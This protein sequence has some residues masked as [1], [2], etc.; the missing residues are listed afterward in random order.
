MA[1]ETNA[2]PQYK[3]PTPKNLSAGRLKRTIFIALF[4]AVIL[5]TIIFGLLF[6][7]QF[8]ETL[9]RKIIQ[10]SLDGLN[11]TV[12]N[13]QLKLA[14]FEKISVQL[15]I[16]KGF[17]TTVINYITS[18][19]TAQL[20]FK[21][22]QIESYFN[23]YMISNQDIFA[24][25]FICDRYPERSFV[26]AKDDH[27]AFLSLTQHFMETHTYQNI[28]KAGGG[29]VW[30][31]SI[32]LGI[33]HYVVLGREIKNMADGEPLGV[34]AIFVDEEKIDQLSNL[35]VYKQLNISFSDLENYNLIINNNGEIVSSPFKDDIG[36]NVSGLMKNTQP[37][38]DIFDNKVS[39]RDYGNEINQGSFITEIN[40]KQTLVTYKTIGSQS[41]IG[42]KS[43]WHMLNLTPTSPLYDKVNKVSVLMFLVAVL[44]GII[45]I[46]AAN[47]I[48]VSIQKSY[49]VE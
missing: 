42:G 47:F 22:S 43:G 31:A 11:Q 3:A 21:K 32:K 48:A 8:Q 15:F 46:F 39:D 29:I 33:S 7:N 49:I 24:F 16:N 40:H 28:R 14:E 38:K 23:E 45:A 27:D 44:F 17:N 37:L 30:S 20:P 34:L 25:M 26:V 36:K 13:I 5:P 2:S 6:Y 1:T 41:G 4:T 9:T 12:V 35:N 19:D 18:K 10:Y